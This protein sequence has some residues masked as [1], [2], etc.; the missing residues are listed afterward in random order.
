MRTARIVL[1]MA[2]AM[3]I[4]APLLAQERGQRDE[5]RRGRGNPAP[6]ALLM[7]ER[8]QTAIGELNLTDEQ[9]EKLAKVREEMGP[10]MKETWGEAEKE[11]LTEERRKAAEE[12]M[13][14]NKE[15]G[16]KGREAVTAIETAI[17]LTDEQKPKM[18]KVGEELLPRSTRGIEEDHGNP[19]ARAAREVRGEDASAKT[20]AAAAST[21]RK[22]RGGEVDRRCTDE[23]NQP[24]GNPQTRCLG[25]RHRNKHPFNVMGRGSI[26]RMS[27]VQVLRPE[28]SP[29]SACLP[30]RCGLRH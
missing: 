1:A 9:K 24:Q 11:I 23:D 12:V 10:K 19:Y 7:M 27:Q 6:R 21:G 2:V 28:G 17:K 13:K 18:D 29:R 20:P 3:L 26:P 4:A 30:R 8:L 5:G 25:G 14:K 22:K 15:A 16:T